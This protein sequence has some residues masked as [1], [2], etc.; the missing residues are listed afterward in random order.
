MES[1][2]ILG[3]WILKMDWPAVSREEISEVGVARAERSRERERERERETARAGMKMDDVYNDPA[4]KGGGGGGC[5][6]IGWIKKKLGG[7]KDRSPALFSFATGVVIGGIVLVGTA[8]ARGEDF[9]E[10]FSRLPFGGSGKCAG[11]KKKG[12]KIT[13][14]VGE[15]QTLGDIIV[16]YVGDYTDA[17]VS[18]IAK[19]NKLKDA[20]MITVGQSLVVTDNRQIEVA[21]AEQAK[22]A[23]V[24]LPAASSAAKGPVKKEERS[25]RKQVRKK[26]PSAAERRMAP[27][28]PAAAARKKAATSAKPA[29]VSANKKG[30]EEGKKT[31]KAKEPV[32]ILPKKEKQRKEK[33]EPAKEEKG[34]FLF[35]GKK[36][37]KAGE[38]KK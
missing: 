22:E 35:F 11:K 9:K 31:V 2:P 16:K 33:G 14:V 17:T 34:G 15:G 37:K 24:S 23:K 29:K 6:P 25:R 27:K 19:E 26:K 1:N 13:V 3:F 20:N 12:P 18:Q 30:P 36:N 38:A 10:T 21:A 28:K 5:G 8:V 4:G 32:V 7:L